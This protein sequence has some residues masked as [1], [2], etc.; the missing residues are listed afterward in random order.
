MTPAPISVERLREVIAFLLGEGELDNRWFGDGSAPL[1]AGKYRAPYWWRTQL[2][3]TTDSLLH[4][5]AERD[6]EVERLKAEV[7]RRHD[8]RLQILQ[9][10]GSDQFDLIK[11]AEAAE[12]AREGA[13]GLLREVEPEIN[14]L[15]NI[16]YS[17]FSNTKR[18]KETEALHSRIAAFLAASGGK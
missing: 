12:R 15:S 6:A 17:E 3:E 13:T 9:D 7:Q 8:E 1:V 10:S 5:L 16:Y 2:R 4:Q 18:E 11:R 14:E